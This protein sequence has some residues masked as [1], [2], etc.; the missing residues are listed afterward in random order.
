M[1]SPAWQK[2]RQLLSPSSVFEKYGT[3]SNE[4]NFAVLKDHLFFAYNS[5]ILFFGLA[6]VFTSRRWGFWSMLT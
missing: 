1:I 5:F 3:A 6:V 2:V 4:K